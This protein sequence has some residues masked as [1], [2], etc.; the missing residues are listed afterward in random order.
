MRAKKKISVTV[1][2][3]LLEEVDRIAGTL[4]RSAVFEQALASWLRQQRK[5]KLD[6]EIEHYY[7]SMTDEEHAGDAEWA[8]LGDESIKEN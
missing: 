7:K 8:T 3:E 2:L 4:S 1:Q 6:L 5:N